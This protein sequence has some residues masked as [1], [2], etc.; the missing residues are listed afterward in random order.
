MWGLRESSFPHS[1]L[2]MCSWSNA[3][4]LPAVFGEKI[5]KRHSSGSSLMCLY[6]LRCLNIVKVG[7]AS[8]FPTRLD[9]IRRGS[10]HPVEVLRAYSHW[11]AEYVKQLER[12][13]HKELSG[14]REHHEFFTADSPELDAVISRLDR[15][16]Q[17]DC[18]P[19]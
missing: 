19:A 6:F 1:E 13:I 12:E 4:R 3:Y 14:I 15:E 18:E 11:D 17:F 10:F 16:F 7:I 2:E 8:S 5:N 9:A